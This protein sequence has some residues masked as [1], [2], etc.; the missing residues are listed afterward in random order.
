MGVCLRKRIKKGFTLV[1]VM[2]SAAIF[3]ILCVGVVESIYTSYT[4]SRTA[5]YRVCAGNV[6]QSYM[7]QIMSLP[8][9]TLKEALTL[10]KPLYLIQLTGGLITSTSDSTLSRLTLTPGNPGTSINHPD[11][12]LMCAPALLK[13]ANTT[14]PF[15]L[16]LTIRPYAADN[17]YLEIIMDYGWGGAADKYSIRELKS[18]V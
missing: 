5:M 7:E 6:A 15:R 18:N 11:I 4:I 8:S 14:N 3:G 16:S 12:T 2:I 17:S 9:A 13:F 10:G 1:E